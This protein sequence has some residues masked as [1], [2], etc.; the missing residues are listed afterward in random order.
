MVDGAIRLLSLANQLAATTRRI[1][2]DFEEGETGTMGYLNR[3]G[4]FDHLHPDIEVLP[5]RPRYSAAE[6]HRGANSTLVEIARINKDV[7]DN[8][9]TAAISRACS[10]RPDVDELKGATWTIFAELID[11]V[12]S[13]SAT[14]VDG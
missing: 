5:E 14:S 4:F 9:L 13:H 6:L 11:N 8:R 3:M 10:G 12:F 1:H 2:L 7:R